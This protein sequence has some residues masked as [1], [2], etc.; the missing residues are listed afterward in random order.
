M[1][2]DGM[3]DTPLGKGCPPPQGT[4]QEQAAHTSSRGYYHRPFLSVVCFSCRG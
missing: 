4:L 1:K 2:G 3:R